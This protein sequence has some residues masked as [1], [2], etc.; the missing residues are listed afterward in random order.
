MIKS[1]KNLEP[2][3]LNDLLN[4]VSES[5]RKGLREVKKIPSP[6]LCPISGV[7]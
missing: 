1:D 7:I 3:E 5:F 4:C 2:D 6:L